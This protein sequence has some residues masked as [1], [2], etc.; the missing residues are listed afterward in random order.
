MSEAEKYFKD[1]VVWNGTV[2]MNPIKLMEDFH[3]SKVESL[4]M[5]QIETILPST[6][7]IKDSHKN[8]LMKRFLKRL[9]QL[10]K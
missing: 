2:V 9:K 10:L 3:N 7:S 4:T 5:D 1:N 8:Y 6:L